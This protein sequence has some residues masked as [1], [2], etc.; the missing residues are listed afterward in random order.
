MNDRMNKLENRQSKTEQNMNGITENLEKAE[1]K[2]NTIE[3][4]LKS[5]S[6]DN[7]KMQQEINKLKTSV[8]SEISVMNLH[9]TDIKD[10]LINK[11]D[12]QS[13]DWAT[14]VS[15]H[16]DEKLGIVAGQV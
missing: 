1:V 15:Q 5:I 9:I 3:M 2:Q 7:T 4:R 16:V 10:E 6:E 11:N 12:T 8:D 14:K 13:S